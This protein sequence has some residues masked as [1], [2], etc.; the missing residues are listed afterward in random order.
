LPHVS[1]VYSHMSTDERKQVVAD[2]YASNRVRNIDGHSA[3]VELRA[4]GAES[5]GVRSAV[6]DRVVVVVTKDVAPEQ[7]KPVAEIV[8]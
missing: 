3:R 4:D 7:W 6:F 1:L 5:E 2:L 8:I